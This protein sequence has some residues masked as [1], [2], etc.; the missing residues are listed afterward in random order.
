MARMLALRLEPS[1]ERPAEHHR[2]RGARRLGV[3]VAVAGLGLALLAPGASAAATVSPQPGSSAASPRTQ[4]SFR[5]VTARQLAKVEVRGSRSGSHRGVVRAHP[6]GAGASFVPT[7]P[8]VADEMVSVRTGL[9]LRGAS[10]G[11]YRIKIAR[12]A[13]LPRAADTKRGSR[14]RIRAFRSRPD[15]QPP[16]IAIGTPPTGAAPGKI[17]IAPKLGKGQGGPMILDEHGRL[18]YFEPMPG[19]TTSGDFRVQTYRG[20]PVLTAWEGASSAGQGHGEGVIRNQRYEVIQRVR[21]G[22]GYLLDLHEFLLTDRGTALTTIYQPVRRD[23]SSIGG[24]RNGVAVDSIVQEIDVAT[25]LVL[26]EWHSLD[27]V[28]LRESVRDRPK[29]GFSYYDYFHV[30]SIAEDGPGALVISA[31]QTS[32]VYK[33]D[34]D[35]GGIAWRLGGT[36]SDFRLGPGAAFRLQHDARLQADGTI[37]IFDNSSTAAGKRTRVL[38]LALDERA[39]TATVVRDVRAP[40]KMFSATQGD[41]QLLSDGALFVGWGSQGRISEI[42]PGGELRFDARLPAGYDTYRGYRMPWSG[43]SAAPPRVAAAVRKG[44]ADVWVSWN[45]ATDVAWWEVLAGPASAALG[46]VVSQPW[47][48]FETRIQIGGSPKRVAVVAHAADGSVLGRSKTVTVGS[49]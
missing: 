36:H 18:V 23:L 48:G 49:G 17:F 10:R 30:N 11:H 14:D 39:R 45:G 4:L 34:R 26:F 1:S 33:I 5:G 9:D 43:R 27:H 37:R 21:G 15:L 38:T 44:G 13:P 28:G 12:F 20:Q 25:G 19:S 8:F 32:A 6:D 3:P 29:R 40:D 47:Q 41:A 2:R 22:N 24:A 7:R 16:S 35:S 46:S 42:G 31:R